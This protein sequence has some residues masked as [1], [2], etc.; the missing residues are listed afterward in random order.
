MRKKLIVTN[1]NKGKLATYNYAWLEHG[2]Q[3]TPHTHVDGEEY[4]LFLKGKGEMLVGTQWFAVAAGDYVVIP[5]G[6]V[7]SLKNTHKTP[8]VFTAIRTVDETQQAL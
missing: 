1:E 6:A 4:Y 5:H 2:K 7:H 3:L 8:L